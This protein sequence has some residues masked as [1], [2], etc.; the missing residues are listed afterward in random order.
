M[1]LK[2]KAEASGYP[3]YIITEQDK[4][5]YVKNYLEKMKESC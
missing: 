5:K 2:M 3:S 1:F 4:S